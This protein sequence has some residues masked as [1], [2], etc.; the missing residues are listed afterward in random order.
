[1]VSLTLTPHWHSLNEMKMT[2]RYGEEAVRQMSAA[3]HFKRIADQGGELLTLWLKRVRK[4]SGAKLRYML[5]TESHKSGLPHWHC[6]L[7]EAEGGSPITNRV[8][9]EAWNYGFSHAKLVKSDAA[10][11]VTKYLAKQ[12]LARVRAS[13]WY[14]QR[15]IVDLKSEQ[16]KRRVKNSDPDTETAQ[17]GDSGGLN[18]VSCSLPRLAAGA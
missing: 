16:V 4:N 15:E 7:H 10:S 14:G 11:Y 3:E 8:I 2:M 1:M 13:A 9:V 5:V 6:L 18:G 12:S 17:S